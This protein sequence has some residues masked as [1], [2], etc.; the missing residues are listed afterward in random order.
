MVIARTLFLALAI[1]SILCFV[2]YMLTGQ[3]RHRRAG[4]LILKATV[5]S[6][7]IFFAVLVLER[8]WKPF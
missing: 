6:G 3:V 2:L 4:L 1:A 8:L 7:L 5:A